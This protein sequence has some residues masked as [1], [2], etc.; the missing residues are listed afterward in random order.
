[1]YN[2]K[3]STKK[4]IVMALKSNFYVNTKIII[5]RDILE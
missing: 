2:M 1:M 4:T 3:I 5:D